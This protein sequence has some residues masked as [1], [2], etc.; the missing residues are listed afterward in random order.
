MRTLAVRGR[1]YDAARSRKCSVGR[2]GTTFAAGDM[3][4]DGETAAP[5]VL[6]LIDFLSDSAHNLNVR[7]HRQVLAGELGATGVEMF[8]VPGSMFTAQLVQ[9]GACL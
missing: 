5:R 1:L 3:S 2:N 8:S 7:K 6:K 9:R 4:V